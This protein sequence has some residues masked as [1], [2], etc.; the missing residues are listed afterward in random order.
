MHVPTEYRVGYWYTTTQYLLDSVPT[1]KANSALVKFGTCQIRHLGLVS[2][3]KFWIY[4]VGVNT[5]CT[6]W[7][8]VTNV[9]LLVVCWTL[10]LLV[11]GIYCCVELHVDVIHCSCQVQMTNIKQNKSELDLRWLYSSSTRNGMIYKCYVILR[12]I[13]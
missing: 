9:N 10:N 2:Y 5:K 1:E 7:Q 6:I 13:V 3:S 4:W 11:F 12:N 8:L